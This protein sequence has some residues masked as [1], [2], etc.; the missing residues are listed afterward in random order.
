MQRVYGYAQPFVGVRVLLFEPCANSI[1]LCLS[2]LARDALLEPR[3]HAERLPITV[4][5]SGREVQRRPYLCAR[6]P[7]RGELKIGRHDADD[8]VAFAVERNL[9]PDDGLVAAEPALPE[10]I[11]QDND[12]LVTGLIFSRKKRAAKQ[13]VYAE[14]MKHIGGQLQSVEVFGP[15]TARK[16][17]RPVLRGS[18][19]VEKLILILQ[20]EKV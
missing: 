16:I 20:V 5:D 4:V 12:M 3:E 15:V 14:Q 18:H 6:S 2:L 19:L 9:L 8:G 17:R 11:A 1:H 10:A 7:E 13:W